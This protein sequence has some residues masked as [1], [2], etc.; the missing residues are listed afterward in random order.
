MKNKNYLLFSIIFGVFLI[1]VCL[2]TF[3][4]Y[5][6]NIYKNIIIE[7]YD[8]IEVS[9]NDINDDKYYQFTIYNIV[10]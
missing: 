7:N 2:L 10:G 9:Y 5:N 1:S 6:D 3:S 4:I 8:N